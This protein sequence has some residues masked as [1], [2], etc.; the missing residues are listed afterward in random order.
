MNNSYCD[1]NINKKIKS[2]STSLN[3]NY[4]DKNINYKDKN[5]KLERKKIIKA[6]FKAYSRIS[7]AKKRSQWICNRNWNNRDSN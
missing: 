3:L 5:S 1:K 7:K 4:K 2:F 6:K